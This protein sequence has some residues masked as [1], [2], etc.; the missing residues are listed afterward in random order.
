ME[1]QKNQQATVKY[2][3]PLV[4]GAGAFLVGYVMGSGR[5]TWLNR[6]LGKIA[7]NLGNV[8]L[9]YFYQS[10]QKQNPQFFTEEERVTH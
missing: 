1:N 8:A 7:Q 3:D 9:I 10:F 6:G 4:I 5:W 2:N